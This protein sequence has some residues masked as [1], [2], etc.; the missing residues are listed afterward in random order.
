MSIIEVATPKSASTK[1]KGDLLEKLAVEFLKTQNYEVAEEVRVTANEL[2]LLCRHSVN[3]RQIYVEC[4]AYR[5]NLSAN[6]LTNLWG[7]VDS[8]DYQEGWLVSTGELGKDAKGFQ[9]EWEMKPADKAQRLSI[10]TPQR[11]ISALVN[12]GVIRERPVDSALE[13]L[14][15]EDL[16]GD[17]LLLITPYGRFWI[18]TILTSGLPEAALVYSAKTNKLVEDGT[19][20]S[21][22]ANTD[23]SLNNL[24]F[25]FVNKFRQSNFEF[26]YPSPVVEVQ[27]GD[28]WSDYRPARPEDFVGRKEEQNRI[29]KFL[30]SV[31]TKESGTRIFAI[32][33]DSGMGKSSLIAKLRSRTR[34]S[35]YRKK[36]YLFAVDVRAA[37]EP[38][39]IY[40]ALLTGLTKAVEHGFGNPPAEPFR[41]SNPTDPLSHPTVQ[42]YL[43]SLEDND[44]VVCIVLD[45]FE[46]LYSKT[47]LFPIFEVTQNLL[48]KV[49]S[50][51][52]S[53]VLGFA[54]KTD[55]TVHQSHPAYYMWHRLSDYRIELQLSRFSYSEASSA[56]TI[57]QKEISTKIR[58]DLRRQLIESS[59]GYPWLLKKLSIHVYEQLRTGVSQ[60]EIMSKALDVQSLFN[61]DLQQL[62]SHESACLKMIAKKSPA[63]WYEVLES[64]DQDTVQSLVQKRLVVRSGDRLNLYW[65]I[66]KEYVLTENVPAIP[67]SYLP[68]SPSLRT[69]LALA[70]LLETD[71]FKSH[72]EL[73]K[74][75][76]I[77]EKSVGNIVRDLIMFGVAAGS[78]SQVRLSDDLESSDP[79]IVLR[80]IRRTL[81]SHA[82][83]LSLAQHSVGTILTLE[84][85][86][87]SLQEI[88]PAAQ[89]QE[90]TWQIY[91]ERMTQWLSAV[92]FLEP[93]QDG[94]K[95]EDRGEE[96][97]SPTN[98]LIRRYYSRHPRQYRENT[99]FIGDT[100]PLR[101]VKALSWLLQQKPQSWKEIEKSGHRNGARTLLNLRIIKNE[102]G[103]YFVSEPIRNTESTTRQC[104][105]NAAVKEPVLELVV[106][107]LMDN[108]TASGTDVGA[109][110]AKEYEREWTEASLQ[111]IG[112]SLKQWGKWLLLGRDN[113]AVPRPLGQRDKHENK[114]QL[115][116]W[117][118]DK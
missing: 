46:E 112:H 3:N 41:I 10:Y 7:T 106:D 30:E 34:N 69:M 100:S 9:H 44:Q 82:L 70:Q 50:S 62:N 47:S 27:Q 31:R 65:D 101:T 92:G 14:E 17:W 107:F 61:R 88:N 115:S 38:S 33:G 66:F 36:Y 72:G 77:S 15:N 85:I 84:H 63:D 110:V 56:I 78:Q 74:S 26:E 114:G 45:Q 89:H 18:A 111:R 90:R 108:P 54:W 80:R 29:L 43:N 49:T 79:K 19:L 52:S 40:G 91:A 109:I 11:V 67:L 57:F 5:D 113:E 35:R 71:I 64:S 28:N 2:D 116:F 21:R 94:W 59:Q 87:F 58:P 104:V 83:T 25:D 12:S 37:T 55:T 24:D 96:S 23:T 4:K 42:R 51:Q 117:Q 32:T 99:L 1:E 76:G 6:I 68:T 22:I 60:S 95:L 8:K 97:I 20:L 16:L 73:G 75:I 39:Y 13:L 48:L 86:I 102:R 93:V 53:L 105:F 81:Q 118:D 98:A 103:K